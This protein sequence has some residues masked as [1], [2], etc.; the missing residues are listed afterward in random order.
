MA[1]DHSA[2]RASHPFRKEL[3]QVNEVVEEFGGVVPV[4][5]EEEQILLSKGLKKFSVDD[6]LYEI[7][8]LYLT[9]FGDGP[10]IHDDVGGSWI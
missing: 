6:Y 7:E 4:P 1:Q 2:P 10:T 5:D 3:E 9:Y 8:D